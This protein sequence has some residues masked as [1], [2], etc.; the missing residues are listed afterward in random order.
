MYSYQRICSNGMNLSHNKC[1]AFLRSIDER[2]FKVNLYS[3]ELD[4]IS[5]LPLKYLSN[6]LLLREALKY[7]I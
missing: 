1:C 6:S 7:T 5:N 4:Y 2:L 3:I